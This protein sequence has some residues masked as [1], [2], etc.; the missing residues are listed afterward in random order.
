MHASSKAT[1]LT[2]GVTAAG[3]CIPVI[4]MGSEVTGWSKES[5]PACSICLGAQ[6][7]CTS[8]NMLRS[9]QHQVVIFC[10]C[11]QEQLQGDEKACAA[12]HSMW[13]TCL[14]TQDSTRAAR[15]HADQCGPAQCKDERTISPY[16]SSPKIAWPMCARCRRIC[17]EPT[18][19]INAH[20]RPE[21]M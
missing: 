7:T 6:G 15:H 9:L 1:K 11:K 14:R 17:T 2:D 13:A 10:S 20:T 16:W 8:A 3:Q 18:T 5:V 12:L 4:V 19:S 21:S